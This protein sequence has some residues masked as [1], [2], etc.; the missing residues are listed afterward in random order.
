MTNFV[1][2]QDLIP[3]GPVASQIRSYSGPRAKYEP[4]A[5]MFFKS[6]PDLAQ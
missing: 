3:D 2:L 4:A 6:H 5:Q 1:G